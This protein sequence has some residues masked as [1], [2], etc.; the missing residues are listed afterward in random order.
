MTRVVLSLVLIGAM[1]VLTGHTGHA[2]WG[3]GSSL[4]GAW[5]LVEPRPAHSVEHIK[6]LSKGRFVWTTVKD[7]RIVRS[8]GGR[9]I[10]R[11]KYYI[12]IIEHVQNDED[13]WMVG[14]EVTFHREVRDGKWYHSTVEG[15]EFSGSEVWTRA[16]R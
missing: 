8:A 3:V 15:E 10:A 5:R 13:G 1:F 14:I 12:E 11:G 16:R 2:D 4:D 7:G 6:V 9:Y